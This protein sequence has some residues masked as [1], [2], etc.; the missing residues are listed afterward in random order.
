MK[1]VAFK[2][3][4]NKFMILLF[5]I[6]VIFLINVFM[7]NLNIIFPKNFSIIE[8]L[9]NKKD[10]DYSD[11]PQSEEQFNLAK[12]SPSF[13][14][15]Y[16]SWCGFCK[17]AISHVVEL[18]ENNTDYVILAID[19]DEK[20]SIAENYQIKSYPTFMFFPNGMNSEG[21][22]YDGKNN[23]ASFQQYLDNK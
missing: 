11:L 9:D 15:F 1:R 20:K 10:L 16:A 12:D 21:I 13:V 14:M 2:N 6:F 7:N 19:V 5:L 22:K 8:S 23:Y 4:K 3:F 18:N 17:K